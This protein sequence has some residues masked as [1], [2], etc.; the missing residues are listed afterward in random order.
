MIDFE[1]LLDKLSFI[2]FMGRSSHH[3]IVKSYAL[4]NSL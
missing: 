3:V 4:N 2:N 1:Y